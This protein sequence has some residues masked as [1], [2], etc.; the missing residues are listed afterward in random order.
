MVFRQAELTERI[1]EEGRRQLESFEE[2]LAEL[3]DEWL[4]S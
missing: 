1:R 4:A 2:R 3:R